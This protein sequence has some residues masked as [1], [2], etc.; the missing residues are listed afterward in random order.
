[1]LAIVHQPDAGPGVFGEAIRAAGATAR[2]VGDRRRRPTPRPTPSATTPCSYSAAPSTPTRG[3]PPLA[4]RRALA[5]AELLAQEKPLLGLCLGAQMLAAAAGATPRRAAR[6]E[7]GWHRVDITAAGREDPLLAPLAPGFDAFQWHS[8]ECP[9]P[10]GAVALATSEVC[11]QAFRVGPAAWGLQF[12]PEVSAADARHWI[13]DYR[14]DPD[15]VGRRR[16]RRPRPRDRDEDR[17]FNQVGRDICRRWLGA[18]GAAQLKRSRDPGG[19]RPSQK[20]RLVLA[21]TAIA[22][23]SAFAGVSSAAAAGVVNGD[24][25]TGTLEGWQTH[26]QTG[27]GEW[28]T[29]ERAEAEEPGE[30]LRPPS[31]KY[32]ALT[33]FHR[34]R[35]SAILYQDVALEP[36]ADHQLS[37]YLYYVAGADR[38]PSP[39][40]LVVAEAGAGR[41]P[42]G[43]SR[44]HE[45]VGADR[46]ARPRRHPRDRLRQ[47]GRRPRELAP[48]RLTADL[49][50][51]AGQTVRLRIAVAAH[52]EPMVAGVDGVSIDQHADPGSCPVPRRP[53]PALEHV[54]Q[55]QADAEPEERDRVARG[56]RARRRDAD[57]DRRRATDR[58]RLARPPTTTKRR[59]RP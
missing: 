57:R 48:T 20:F 39:N 55:G 43:P 50:A 23:L 29:Y 38:R 25:E 15:A 11:L 28:V 13:E 22:A 49:S 31:G 33:E 12:H 24:F 47:Q 3:P 51:F 5:A 26:Y 36:A 45:A 10:P 14:S 53:R 41:K 59:G 7:I 54:R 46:I 34:R 9:L 58:D 1:M 40:T 19:R 27:E 52:E 35:D 30:I 17:A 21:L 42:A 6:P 16:P 18:A 32:A 8:Y 56:H 2:G 4:R 44:R 37:M